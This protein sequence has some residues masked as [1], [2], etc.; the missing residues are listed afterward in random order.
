MKSIFH[1]AIAA[2][3]AM[4]LSA[5]SA[6]AA[7]TIFGSSVHSESGVTGSSAALG[8][9]DAT[10][11]TVGSSG[12]LVLQ[13]LQPLTGAGISFDILPVA[14]INV[15]AV[16]IGEVVG[17]I[18]T[19]SATSFIHLDDGLGASVAVADLSAA[20]ASV[21]AT[22]CSLLR[23]QNVLAVGSPGFALDGV[24]GVSN[25]PEPAVWSLMI[26]GFAFTAWRL[27]A[28]RR[29]DPAALLAAHG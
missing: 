22:G 16:S 3:A 28:E 27:K 2:I 9:P 20:C 5:Q 11:A 18:A 12:E 26:L 21:S 17:G 1:A 29:R 25:A 10:G 23:F 14:G 24:S 7:I 6:N 8:V 15:I 4:S 19:F 13:F